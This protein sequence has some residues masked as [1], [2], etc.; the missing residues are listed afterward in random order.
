MN[1]ERGILN[2]EPRNPGSSG[3][4]DRDLTRGRPLVG[5]MV[6]AQ[7]CG[8]RPLVGAMVTAQTCGYRPLKGAMVIAQASAWGSS[9]VDTHPALKGPT[10]CDAPLPDGVTS[11]APSGRKSGNAVVTQGKPWALTV[12]AFSAEIPNL[13]TPEPRSHLPRLWRSSV[14]RPRSRDKRGRLSYA[15]TPE[16]RNL[17]TTNDER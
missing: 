11:R 3:P 15:G 9:G 8:Y 5:A 1:D 10:S 17:G 6:T 7:T 4:A 12:G 13:G 16:P 2:L 14:R